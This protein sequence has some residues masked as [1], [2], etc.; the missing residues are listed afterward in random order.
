MLPPWTD[1]FRRKRRR[2]SIII[3]NL[4]QKQQKIFNKTEYAHK[5]GKNE[6]H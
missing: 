5:N 3:N 4:F 1:I 2:K 6:L